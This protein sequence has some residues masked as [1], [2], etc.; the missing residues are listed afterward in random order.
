MPDPFEL[1]D[2]PPDLQRPPQSI[3]YFDGLEQ[4]QR[5]AVEATDGP[6]LVGRVILFRT[7]VK[8]R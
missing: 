7:L 2:A 5:K 8:F 4:N 3:S 1:T 6:V